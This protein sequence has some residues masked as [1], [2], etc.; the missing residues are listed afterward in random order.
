MPTLS[1]PRSAWVAVL[2]LLALLCL[3]PTGANAATDAR[4]TPAQTAQLLFVAGDVRRLDRAPSGTVDTVLEQILQQRYRD[5]PGFEPADAQ[6][7]I[8]ALRAALNT[9]DRAT[10]PATLEALPGNQRVLAVLA[11]FQRSR[12]PA[13]VGHAL[14][15]VADRALTE[16]S[17]STLATPNS[18]FNATA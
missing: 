11:A 7:E 13:G 4:A 10:T 1:P 5:D 17:T 2:S 9:G 8:D 15:R 12:P 14:A 16:A 3:L 18:R 6:R